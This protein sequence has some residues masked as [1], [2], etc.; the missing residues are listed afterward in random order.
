MPND[1]LSTDTIV[2][3]STAPGRGGIGIVRL[4][5]PEALR[6]AERLVT[7]DRPLEHAR[8]RRVRVLDVDAAVEDRAKTIDEAVVT[9]FVA[10]RSY[11][12]ETVVEIAAHGE[13]GQRGRRGARPCG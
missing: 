6:V 9:A 1:S 10:P 2:A 4:S 8:A 11:T 12:G 5:G 3:I 13:P 7:L